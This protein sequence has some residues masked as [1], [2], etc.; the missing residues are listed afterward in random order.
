[1]LMLSATI[2]QR[3]KWKGGMNKGKTNSTHRE[4]LILDMCAWSAKPSTK[5]AEVLILDLTLRLFTTQ[6]RAEEV[7]LPDESV[8]TDPRA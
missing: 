1:M 2:T 6:H 5:E 7:Q 3:E 8:K 4:L